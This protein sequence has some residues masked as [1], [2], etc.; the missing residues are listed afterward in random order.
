MESLHILFKDVMSLE[1]IFDYVYF[2]L[3]GNIQSFTKRI[4]FINR[5]DTEKFSLAAAGKLFRLINNRILNRFV[6]AFKMFDAAELKNY[7][8]R[9]HIENVGKVS[10]ST[11]KLNVQF[12]HFH[13]PSLST[14]SQHSREKACASH[15]AQKE[16]LTTNAYNLI[17]KSV[18]KEKHLQSFPSICGVNMSPLSRNRD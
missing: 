18:D 17:W 3:T 6:E 12:S 2:D 10:H 13:A 8:T 1:S 9:K 7:Q 14:N 5:A 11:R 16:K 15:C 4:L